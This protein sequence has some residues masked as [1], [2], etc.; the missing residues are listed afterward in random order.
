[1]TTTITDTQTDVPQVFDEDSIYAGPLEESLR[2]Y[3][4]APVSGKHGSAWTSDLATAQRFAASGHGKVWTAVFDPEHLLVHF[5]TRG[6]FEYTVDPS[7]FDPEAGCTAEVDEYI[8]VQAAAAAAST[9][10]RLVPHLF[11]V[12]EMVDWITGQRDF[13]AEAFE[14]VKRHVEHEDVPSV[15]LNAAEAGAFGT[16]ELAAA[17]TGVWSGDGT[18]STMLSLEQWRFLF[19][20]A[21]YTKDG[22]AAE[23]PAEPMR[24]Y[25][26]APTEGKVGMSWTSDLS[27]AEFFSRRLTEGEE[28]AIWTA[29]FEPEH[30]LAHIT[31]RDECEYVVD[32]EALASGLI[33]VE[34][35]T[36]A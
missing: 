10:E 29:V 19:T 27:I 6:E 33:E 16:T 3:R 12:E 22:V 9:G 30:L 34:R 24:L 23:H 5:T 8:T 21:G 32:P 26:G 13:T 20:K 11:D 4:G 17:L 7:A 14:L 2:L 28:E 36:G 1:M 15:L 25:R 35:Y 18:P 31:T